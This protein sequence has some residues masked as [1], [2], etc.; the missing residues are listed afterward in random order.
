V[1]TNLWT[2][3]LDGE[4]YA[5]VRLRLFVRGNGHLPASTKAHGWTRMP[6]ERGRVSAT[7]VHLR[8]RRCRSTPESTG[9][10]SVTLLAD[11]GVYPDWAKVGASDS[12]PSD[13]STL[14]ATAISKTTYDDLVGDDDSDNSY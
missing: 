5:R 10:V 2:Q 7:Y 11:A 13:G 3:P 6:D 9:S 14:G 4:E 12:A 1:K 8:L